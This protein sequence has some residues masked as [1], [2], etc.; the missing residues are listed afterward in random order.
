MNLIYNNV[1]PSDTTHSFPHRSQKKRETTPIN[2]YV[3]T[4][5]TPDQIDTTLPFL[6]PPTVLLLPVPQIQLHSLQ[7]SHIY[8]FKF[9]IP[10]IETPVCLH[11]APK[12]TQATYRSN[13]DASAPLAPQH[14]PRPRKF[15]ST[16]KPGCTSERLA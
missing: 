2:A 3:A 5:Y 10:D 15:P 1:V 4:A 16:W 14:R 8:P 11:P 13:Q 7:R 6:S 12:A 9:S